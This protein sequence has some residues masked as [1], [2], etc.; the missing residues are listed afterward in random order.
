MGSNWRLVDPIWREKNKWNS[1][2]FSFDP[3]E[4]FSK[5][6]RV[7]IYGKRKLPN[8]SCMC[9]NCGSVI[10]I[11]GWRLQEAKLHSQP[12]IYCDLECAR[13]DRSRVY[14]TRGIA[15]KSVIT[16]GHKKRQPKQK[17]FCKCCNKEVKHG[18][19]LLCSEQCKQKVEREK[20]QSRAKTVQC[21]ICGVAFTKL[22][23]KGG[24]SGCCSVKC[25]NKDASKSGKR[26]RRNRLKKSF[27]KD[28]ISRAVV[29]GDAKWACRHCGI[30]VHWPNGK[31]LPT[32]ATIDHV[33]PI[34]KGGLHI[35]SNVQ[36]LCRRCNTAKGA[37]LD[38]PTQI[39]MF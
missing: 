20:Y 33:V 39:M 9:Q 4:A 24:F 29:F 28:R 38:K 16:K 10:V 15:G 5:Y 22:P 7:K 35:Y 8:E 27:R 23:T 12:E 18:N 17:R 13:E 1:R 6:L 2:P 36:C 30:T 26:S 11:G 32:E 3:S 19:S 37:S 25:R 31:H 14:R 34:A 21:K